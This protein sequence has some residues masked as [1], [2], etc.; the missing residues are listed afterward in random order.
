MKIGYSRVST[1]DQHPEAQE[2]ELRAAGAE[3]VFTDLGQ[4]G[5][6]AS[7]PEWDRLRDQL[8]AGDVLMITK[9]DRAGRSVKHLVE[10]A[11]WLKGSGID[12][13]VT[14]QG[15][16]TSTPVGR[17]LFHVLAAIAEFEADLGRERTFDGLKYAAS[18]GRHGGGRP[19]LTPAQTREVRKMFDAGR[20]PAEI[21]ALFPIS[22]AT[23]YRIVGADAA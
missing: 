17:M 16:D 21:L 5:R 15:I 13:V 10:L 4:S 18:Q 6:K 2:A 23:L 8:R 11:E 9:L 20:R 3:R 22:R 1:N 14:S 12:L 19:K 7:R